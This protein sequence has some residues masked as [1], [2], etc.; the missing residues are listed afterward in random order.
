M[1]LKPAQQGSPSTLKP[2]LA[3]T[4]ISNTFRRGGGSAPRGGLGATP[5]RVTGSENLLSK[6]GFLAYPHFPS[7]SKVRKFERILYYREL[8]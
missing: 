7:F 6:E 2:L 8:C 3:C 1:L 4:G 5:P